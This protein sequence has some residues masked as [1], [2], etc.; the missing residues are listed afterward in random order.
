MTLKN[1]GRLLGKTKLHPLSKVVNFTWE[2]AH[3]A[4]LIFIDMQTMVNRLQS[5]GH[6]K[7]VKRITVGDHVKSCFQ[8]R[9]INYLLTCLDCFKLNLI[10]RIQVLQLARLISTSSQTTTSD[11]EIAQEKAEIQT[12]IVNLHWATR[13]L[14]DL[15]SLAELDAKRAAKDP[16]HHRINLT[17]P[18]CI[19]NTHDIT[20]WSSDLG[21][22]N[23]K[24]S[25][26]AM[27][28]LSET[29]INPL[30]SHWFPLLNTSRLHSTRK[31]VHYADNPQTPHMV[32]PSH[33]EKDSQAW[34]IKHYG[35]SGY[36]LGTAHNRVRPQ[37]Q[38]VPHEEATVRRQYSGYQGYFKSEA[39]EGQRR[40]SCDTS[41]PRR[42]HTC[43]G[44]RRAS[45]RKSLDSR[46]S[47]KCMSTSEVRDGNPVHYY[48]DARRTPRH[49]H[50]HSTSSM[51]TGFQ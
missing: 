8:K 41:R 23:L 45:V 36:P 37:S 46:R 4:Q 25:P 29:A 5:S 20:F 30:F 51:E 27:G 11:D 49:H 44:E 35:I 9:H 13:I 18:R 43:D 48:H 10:V 28:E 7:E 16:I 3:Q 1:A 6:D 33:S 47:E 12:I 31:S 50:R 26:E 15:W 34:P 38:Q 42:V 17:P 19:H 14:D 40:D 32:N 21:L 39:G 24:K 22:G 2:I